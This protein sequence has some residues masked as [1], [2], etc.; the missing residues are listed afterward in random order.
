MSTTTRQILT[1]SQ[2]DSYRR[3]LAHAALVTV[4]V[5]KEERGV[6]ATEVQKILSART[7]RG[8]KVGLCIFVQRPIFVPGADDASMLGQVVQ[9]FTVLEHPTLNAGDL[10]TGLSAEEVA[11][12]LLQL[13]Q[14]TPIG[15][16]SRQAWSAYPGG[17]VVPD[18]SFDGFNGYET[19]M[20]SFIG[21]PRDERCGLPLISPDEG[22]GTQTVTLSTAT[23]GAS[24]YYTLDGTYPYSGNATAVLYS[25]PFVP[26]AGKRLRC[27]AFKT[28]LQQSGVAETT[29][30]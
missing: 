3:I 9:A 20:Q 21:I 30:D 22:A 18:D 13:F 28:G 19:R 24:I 16:N 8:G 15:A 11:L 14:G 4:A 7:A 29:F 17:S 12:E 27:A 5:V 10:G 25:A 26:G 2:E 6:T 23:A 1:N